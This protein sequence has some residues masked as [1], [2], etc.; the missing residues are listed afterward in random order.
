MSPPGP[1][2]PG[3]T[4]YGLSLEPVTGTRGQAFSAGPLMERAKNKTKPKPKL[5]AG[6]FLWGL[7]SKEK[8]GISQEKC[9]G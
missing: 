3:W 8:K 9:K 7:R 6:D 5:Q 1:P 4:V 2:D